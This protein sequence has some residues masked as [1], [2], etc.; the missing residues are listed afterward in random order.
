M[1]DKKMLDK[2]SILSANVVNDIIEYS[3]DLGSVRVARTGN[4]II[5]KMFNE[6]SICLNFDVENSYKLCGSDNSSMSKIM[7]FIIMLDKKGSFFKSKSEKVIINFIKKIDQQFQNKNKEKLFN[8]IS[9]IEQM[10]IISKDKKNLD[11]LIKNQEVSLKAID[12]DFFEIKKFLNS[13][14]E[15]EESIFLEKIESNYIKNTR[16]LIGLRKLKSDLVLVKSKIEELKKEQ[17]EI[18]KLE[19]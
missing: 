5:M 15:E 19:I 1:K 12:E 18:M 7:F 17:D 4:K 8:L 16:S 10:N 9:K 2:I 11:G 6:D 13:E 14:V 3:V